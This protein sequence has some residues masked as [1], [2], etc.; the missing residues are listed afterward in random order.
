MNAE[1]MDPKCSLSENELRQE[2]L[3]EAMLRSPRSALAGMNLSAET[4]SETKSEIE[5]EIESE[6]M[7]LDLNSDPCPDRLAD[8]ELFGRAKRMAQALAPGLEPPA[9]V[10][11]PDDLVAR[12]LD[13]CLILLPRQELELELG[14]SDFDS[15]SN[16]AKPRRGVF[17][18][19]VEAL[20]RLPL[21]EPSRGE[22]SEH[23]LFL[24]AM[25]QVA[26]AVFVF[27]GCSLFWNVFQPAYAA[28]REESIDRSTQLRLRHLL[29][30]ARRM[31]RSE[32][33]EAPLRGSEL[34]NRL[35]KGGYA[36]IT[37]FHCPGVPLSSPRDVQFSGTLPAVKDERRLPVFWDK[38]NNHVNRINVVF[39]DGSTASISSSQLFD[40]LIPEAQSRD[41]GQ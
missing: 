4:K 30:A 8:L 12:T 38:F 3:L 36:D 15:A 17:G 13:R 24:R 1:A 41:S 11:A 26:A 39:S 21:D 22:I 5:S 10:A 2:A 25:T 34:V 28:A 20:T 16:V 9:L 31:Q 37:D 29:D 35:I 18:S 6:I 27:A 32:A 23:R 7:N 14:E 40:Y 33:N 19:S